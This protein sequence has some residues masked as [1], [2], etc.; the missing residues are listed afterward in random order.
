MKRGIVVTGVILSLIFFLFW[1]VS[2]GAYGLLPAFSP[3]VQ[4]YP[5]PSWL[6]EGVRFVHYGL[7]GS[8]PHDKYRY[9]DD[10]GGSIVDRDGNRWRQEDYPG[11]S[12]QGLIVTDVVSLYQG[13][14]ILS[15]KYYLMMGDSILPRGLTVVRGSLGFVNEFWVHPD[16]LSTLQE[17]TR[18]GL[19]ISRA[20]YSLEGTTYNAIYFHSETENARNIEIYDVETGILLKKK[21]YRYRHRIWGNLAR[22]LPAFIPH[23]AISIVRV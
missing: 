1:S 18:A 4:D 21:F 7:S 22:D 16:F 10:E 3:E 17:E 9:F 12:G 19:R 23:P 5:A 11:T 14:A 13:E 6:N 15:L 20:P 8:I 2:V